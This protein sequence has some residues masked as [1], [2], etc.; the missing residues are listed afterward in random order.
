MNSFAKIQFS[1]F[2]SS[3]ISAL[4][5][6]QILGEPPSGLLINPEGFGPDKHKG[7]VL[8]ADATVGK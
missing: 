3:F 4:A 6:A 8:Q 1:R 2:I 5:I 7:V